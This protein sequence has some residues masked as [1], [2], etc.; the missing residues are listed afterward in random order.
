MGHE[1]VYQTASEEEEA[2]KKNNKTRLFSVGAKFPRSL[3][4][5][6][7]DSDE[8]NLSNVTFAMTCRT[9]R[10]SIKLTHFRLIT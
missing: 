1:L 4:Y 9:Q 8:G 10:K 7:R 3:F 5:G 6:N 2:R